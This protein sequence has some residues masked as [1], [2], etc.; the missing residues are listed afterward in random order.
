MSTQS[1]EG[2]DATKDVDKTHITLNALPVF[3]L[4]KHLL[5]LCRSVVSNNGFKDL[6]H[7]QILHLIVLTCDINFTMNSFGKIEWYGY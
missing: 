6:L 3:E 7:V 2:T 5:P 4:P 1:R